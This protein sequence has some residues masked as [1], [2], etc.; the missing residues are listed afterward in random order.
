GVPKDTALNIRAT[1]EFVVNLVD[2]AMAEQMN[3]CAIDFPAGT[4]ELEQ[5]RLTCVPSERVRPPRIAESPVSFACREHAT[6]EIGRNRIVL[7]EVLGMHVRDE[8]LDA[9]DM[10]VRAEAMH[11]IGRMQGGGWYLKTSDIF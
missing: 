10:H 4:N 8:L 7:G 2:E 6:L 1:R 3:I 11:L 9:E 5:A